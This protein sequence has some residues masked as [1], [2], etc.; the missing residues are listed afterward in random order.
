MQHFPQAY[1]IG[2][3]VGLGS[4]LGVEVDTGGEAEGEGGGVTACTD[5]AAMV[6]S[7]RPD[8]VCVDAPARI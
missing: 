4:V 1:W 3:C 5:G 6:A 7:A 8:D 2:A